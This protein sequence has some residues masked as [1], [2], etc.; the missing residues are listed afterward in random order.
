MPKVKV[1]FLVEFT[2]TIDW[3][4]DEMAEFTAENLVCNLDP[5]SATV[6]DEN[7]ELIDVLVDGKPKTF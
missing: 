4:E 5:N 2:Q 1:T 7:F 3:P 6:A